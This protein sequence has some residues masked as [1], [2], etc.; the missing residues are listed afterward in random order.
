MTNSRSLTAMIV[1]A[2]ALIAATLS[3]QL[4]SAYNYNSFRAT[5]DILYFDESDTTSSCNPST[6]TISANDSA[7]LANVPDPWRSLILS[8][9]PTYP[10]ADARLVAA[11]LWA[12]NRGWPDYNKQWGVSSAGAA[13]PW[14]FITS[15]WAGLGTDGDGDGIKD[16]NNPKDAVHGAFKHQLGSA[17][18]PLINGFTGDL[19]AGLNLVFNRDRQNLLSFMASYNGRGAPNGVALKDFP[20]NENS[21]YVKMGYYL[22]GSGFT[23]SWSTQTGQPISLSG[24]GGGT[25]VNAGIASQNCNTA[26]GIVDASGYAFPIGLA[27]SKISNGYSW[28]CEG[29]CH[30][31]KTPAFD[32]AHKETVTSGSSRDNLTVG[33]PVFAIT[34]GK[35]Q[36]LSNS[37]KGISGCNS[38]QLKGDD[39]WFYWYGHIDSATVREGQTVTAGQ[40]IAKIG[41]R[42]C[43]GNGSYPHLHIDRG[44]PKGEIGGRD[45]HRDPAFIPL[46]NTL[47]QGL[48]N[49]TLSI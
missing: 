27:K 12:E 22:I 40:Q 11:T 31:D 48:P 28:P 44:F 10:T 41:P 42:K 26:A 21:D 46:I 6:V 38:F 14:Q 37:Y 17:G 47:Y 13:G 19:T 29:I 16:R 1:A 34:A 2:L 43:T 32:L 20:R 25:T 8:T 35:I 30:H 15:T 9:A 18:K 45:E 49:D 23:Q 5:N 7:N 36:S 3:T 33:V 39:G 24:E 4:V